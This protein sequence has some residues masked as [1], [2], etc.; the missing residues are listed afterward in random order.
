MSRP[1]LFKR[2]LG[3]AIVF[4]LLFIVLS[5][6]QQGK[7]PRGQ[8][9]GTGG[10]SGGSTGNGSPP[11]APSNLV[12][13]P[14][15]GQVSLAWSAG[16]GA[17]TYIVFRSV[18]GGSFA[19]YASGI[20][21]LAYT[22]SAVTDGITYSYEV[23][24]M[25][26]N[27]KQSTGYAGPASA[28]PEPDA[29]TNLVA[30]PYDAKVVLNWT[31]GAGA[32][33][34]NIV[35]S[36]SGGSYTTIATAVNGVSYTDTGL[37][38]GTTYSY[39]VYSATPYGTQSAS[40]AGPASATPKPAPPT[41]TNL[42]A[43]GGTSAATI[44]LTWSASNTATSYT[45]LSGPNYAL[46]GTTTSGTT[47]TIYGL[48][49]G[50]T[51]TFEVT[52]S[53]AYGTSAPSAPAWGLTLPSAPNNLLASS[54]DTTVTLNWDSVTSATTYTVSRLSGPGG[55]PAVSW[56]S[57]TNSFEDIGLQ[58]GTT[59]Y[60]SVLA[61]NGTGNGPV[62]TTDATPSAPGG[63]HFPGGGLTAEY[64]NYPYQAVTEIDPNVDSTAFTMPPSGISSSSSWSCIWSG[65][66]TPPL[67]GNY[68][69]TL[70]PTLTFSYI[71]INGATVA[72]QDHPSVS[73]ALQEGQS[74]PIV[75]SY[76]STLPGG[77]RLQ[78]TGP[79]PSASGTIP[80]TYFS[81]A[82]VSPLIPGSVSATAGAGQVT[83]QWT[84]ATAAGGTGFSIFRA[85]SSAREQ[86][87]QSPQLSVS[88]NPFAG[89]KSAVDSN[90]VAPGPYY[91]TVR[92][93]YTNPVTGTATLSTPSAEVSATPRVG[94]GAVTGL[95][96]TSRTS[97]VNLSWQ[98]VSNASG[99][100]V[101]RSNSSGGT[102]SAIAY[103]VSGTVFSD[104]PD[105]DPGGVNNGQAY[106]YEVEA[107]DSTDTGPASS[108][109]Q[110]VPIAAPGNLSST[111][112]NGAVTIKWD[113]SQ[114]P[115]GYTGATYTVSRTESV[116]QGQ[117]Q[118]L[119]SG[120]STLTY[121]D[122]TVVP[123]ATYYYNVQATLAA[124]PTINLG[125]G[126]SDN[127]AILKV[128][129][130]GTISGFISPNQEQVNAYGFLDQ[131]LAL[132]DWLEQTVPTDDMASPEGGPT[133]MLSVS[134]PYGTEDCDS[135]PDLV[136]KNPAGPDISF[137]RTYHSSLAYAGLCSPGLTRGW[138]HNWDYEIHPIQDGAYWGQ[139]AL[140]YPSGAYDILTP[141]TDR[142]GNL[143]SPDSNGNYGFTAPGGA[144]YVVTGVPV[145]DPNNNNQPVPGQW[146]T[147]RLNYGGNVYR[148]FSFQLVGVPSQ[149]YSSVLNLSQVGLG[150]AMGQNYLT[151]TYAP[152]IPQPY[153]PPVPTLIGI[154]V[155]NAQSSQTT[156]LLG[157]SFDLSLNPATVT[158]KITQRVVSL[159]STEGELSQ[160]SA[161]NGGVIPLWTYFTSFAGN[162]LSAG[163]VTPPVLSLT[164]PGSNKVSLDQ[165][166]G[167][168]SAVSDE[169]GNTR[170]YN[171]GSSSTT[172]WVFPPGVDTT[173]TSN[174]IDNFTYGFGSTGQGTSVTNSHGDTSTAIYAGSDPSVVTQSNTA[175]ESAPSTAS[176]TYFGGKACPN[177]V[178]EPYGNYTKLGWESDP[179]SPQGRLTT[180]QAYG[181]DNSAGAKTTVSYYSDSE[182][183]PGQYPGYVKSIITTAPGSTTPTGATVESDYTYTALGNVLTI[184]SPGAN[185]SS[186]P[187]VTTFTY[188]I[189]TPPTE[190]VG[191]PL[192]VTDPLGRVTSFQWDPAGSGNLLTASSTSGGKVY[193]ATYVYNSANQVYSVT[194]ASTAD[195]LTRTA[196]YTYP[197]P[198]L[199]C[200]GVV[201]QMTDSTG[202]STGTTTQSPSLDTEYTTTHFAG[203]YQGSSGSGSLNTA[204]FAYDPQYLLTQIKN[205]NGAAVH[206]FQ[207]IPAT[208]TAKATLGGKTW[209][210]TTDP[211][212]VPVSTSDPLGQTTSVDLEYGDARPYQ[213]YLNSSS[214]SEIIN[215]DVFGRVH[216]EASADSTRSEVFSYDLDG[217]VT[218]KTVRVV[219]SSGSTA[220]VLATYN[221]QYTY[222]SNGERETMK[223][224]PSSGMGLTTGLNYAYSYDDDGELT[225]ITLTTFDTSTPN[226]LNQ[227][228]GASIAYVYDG[229]GRVTEAK[230]GVVDTY[231]TY[232][233]LGEVTNLYNLATGAAPSG[234]DTAAPTGGTAEMILSVHGNDLRRTGKPHGQHIPTWQQ[235]FRRI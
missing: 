153:D 22:D 93:A 167:R 172:V 10:T 68:T 3:L 14:S 71:T 176:Y 97:Q 11:G 76:K 173:N 61:T 90:A 53:N 60:Y 31:A 205:G 16:S 182:T 227:V 107:A 58:N 24:S 73:V 200:V 223:V 186:I 208:L 83:I 21:T 104:T 7:G 77:V 181:N 96:A 91:Y 171:Y 191:E 44:V 142:Y 212:G 18:S 229:L 164:E 168:V 148:Q 65:Y 174:A 124:N 81:P 199:P 5:P 46:P 59:Y 207:N 84:Q 4:C 49:P 29:P 202:A 103:G 197:A 224:I 196:T 187:A 101:L 213:I 20:S 235:P 226:T 116:S 33:G 214:P 63:S 23:Y 232:N 189:T 136:V 105:T 206:Q 132:P 57:A 219:D 113:A 48:A 138:V 12:A 163:S 160:A 201:D 162:L 129:V 228:P 211:R 100:T 169:N 55:T 89:S 192:S 137:E 115:S 195:S 175:G 109:V 39:E 194:Q 94:L 230:S 222:Y 140:V 110:A 184:S 27:G 32:T 69:F 92:A 233:S 234:S 108:W 37:T 114:V 19:S 133:S 155:Y 43:N 72:G 225:G 99:Y 40:Y 220:G 149:T 193:T 70:T 141:N 204:A 134:L 6:A 215:Y 156:L 34:Y 78:W 190:I 231:Y 221:I 157:T 102:F 64:T 143:Q 56:V 54:G 165:A 42:S 152:L 183:A 86:Y 147:I 179:L 41:P 9:V 210:T 36:V 17:S 25:N 198:G 119:A 1:Y 75:V 125:S 66:I 216:S 8:V 98:P 51:C 88:P 111:Q 45:I 178:T 144:P 188:P 79:P 30:T 154:S 128:V 80:T 126:T 127:S 112:A 85:P 15:N 159:T 67:S 52:A 146:S 2:C 135:G 130:S 166:T 123:G 131:P 95:A 13:T 209:T 62:S 185:G 180:I 106:F 82:V 170:L 158:D 120:I 150:S 203:S 218:G 161:P 50:T 74:Y 177:Q 87:D 28:T 122:S 47:S 145:L 26:P 217:N 38:D 118:T 139:L 151:L 121:A 117:F 35:R